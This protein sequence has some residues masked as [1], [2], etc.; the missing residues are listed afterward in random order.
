[1]NRYSRDKA[2]KWLRENWDW[3]KET[4]GSDKSYDHYPR[5]AG[6]TLSTKEQLNEY[7]QFFE[8]MKSDPALTRTIEVG[9]NDIT[10][11]ALLI[12]RDKQ[13]V[14]KALSNL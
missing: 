1:M 12:E 14:K 6:S 13:A 7:I 2:W 9:I 3:I 10:N 4:F 8:P 5:Y 11:R